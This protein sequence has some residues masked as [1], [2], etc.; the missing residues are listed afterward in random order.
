MRKKYWAMILVLLQAI[1]FV[2]EAQVAEAGDSLLSQKTARRLLL[3]SLVLP[4]WGEHSLNYHR[5]GFALN[6]S[7]LLLWVG[8]AT[9]S[10]LGNSA[11][12]DMQA[13]A[14]R[15]AGINPVGKDI[16]Y[17]T[18]I[19]NYANI[20]E[21][22]EQKMRYRQ[23]ANLYPE[24]SEYFWAWDSEAS[25]RKFDRL[26]Y[27]SQQILHIA[28]F[29]I[30]GLVVNRIISVIDIIALT[31]ERLEPVENSVQALVYP[32]RDAVTF[33]LNFGFR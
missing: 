12:Q 9:L 33:T 23:Y 14:A 2:S 29:A 21:Y 16:Y 32:Q 1:S 11:E 10:Y 19:G 22:N 15:H 27:N 8:F 17:F 30:G 13:Y 3:Q 26:R 4:G 25:R 5:R 28:S 18:D 20:Y 31:K 7:E 24:S 6:S